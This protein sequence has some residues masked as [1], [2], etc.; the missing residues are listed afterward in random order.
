M[1]FSSPSQ[2]MSRTRANSIPENNAAGTTSIEELLMRHSSPLLHGSTG[3]VVTSPLA[4]R[5]SSPSPLRLN[6]PRSNPRNRTPMR[7]AEQEEEPRCTR[8]DHLMRSKSRKQGPSHRK[9]R[10][11]N[12]DNFVNLAAELSNHKGSAS[13]VEA[14]L[15]GA[16]NASEH[17]SILDPR[18]HESK[19]MKQFREDKSLN[20]VREKF[21]EGSLPC[22]PYSSSSFKKFAVDT[23]SLTPLE[24]FHRIE[25]RLRRI[26][27]KACENSYAASKVVNALE[28][29]LVRAYNGEKDERS[30]EEW[31]EFLLDSPIVTEQ[32]C[33][34]QSIDHQDRKSKCNNRRLI[35]N[36]LF[37][38][39]STTGGFHRL[40]LHGI[41][42]FHC[43]RATSSSTRIKI[44]SK[45]CNA[46]KKARILTATGTLLGAD[47]RLVEFITE[48]Q[49]RFGG[50]S[51]SFS[52]IQLEL[53]TNKLSK[54]KV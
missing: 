12:Y 6:R 3:E 46:T 54:L 43:L 4:E 9:A 20:L 35:I 15:S 27:V 7:I 1:S 18:E 17:R 34:M 33:E 13:A 10:R 11:R 16:A 21:F 23:A 30:Q 29:F 42:Q 32:R 24:R 53:T 5:T 45:D 44:S 22:D 28:D 51:G 26:V 25:S 41:C 49:N 48:R 31:K 19:A 47:V 36:F 50:S 8:G 40:L 39:D 37:D 52:Q 14:L 2:V 38:A